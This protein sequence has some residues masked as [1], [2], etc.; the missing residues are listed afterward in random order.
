VLQMEETK[1]ISNI[2]KL[3][4][5][6]FIIYLIGCN[7]KKNDDKIT[8]INDLKRVK[9]LKIELK[10]KV[11]DYEHLIFDKSNEIRYLNG[12][13]NVLNEFILHFYF[14]ENST[15]KNSLL[16][17][18]TNQNKFTVFKKGENILVKNILF[19]Y[20]GDELTSIEIID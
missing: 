5:S 2:K 8:Q 11:L 15:D 3:F 9:N 17:F 14:G 12:K 18:Y 16:R 4:F 10:Y 1:M 13:L 19:V 6:L 7:N 20:Q